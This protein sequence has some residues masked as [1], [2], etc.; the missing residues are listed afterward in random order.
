MSGEQVPQRFQIAYPL[1]L[2]MWANHNLQV[3]HVCKYSVHSVRNND[4]P[5][6][7]R[8]AIIKDPSEPCSVSH[9]SQW[10]KLNQATTQWFSP[11][12]SPDAR[13][14]PTSIL[15][16]S[17]M[18]SLWPMVPERY[19][20]LNL[21]Y[22]SFHVVPSSVASCGWVHQFNSLQETCA[23]GIS[24]QRNINSNWEAIA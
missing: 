11:V 22:L 4:I 18:L 23:W 21:T 13:S 1:S 10:Q 19:L 17:E 14:I 15:C 7:I 20:Y 8:M 6:S 9:G 3:V 24:L 2:F 16:K 12:C 5:K